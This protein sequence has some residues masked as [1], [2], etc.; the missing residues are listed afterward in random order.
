MAQ[1]PRFTPVAE[2]ALL[3]SFGDAIDDASGAAVLALDRAL[4]AAPPHG[5]TECVPAMVNLLVGFDPLR[6]DHDAVRAHVQQLLGRDAGTP[7]AGQLREVEVCYEGALAPDLAAVARAKG[8]SADAVIEQHL[9]GDYRVRMYGFA[10]G[11]AYLSGVPAA[12][13][14]PRKAAPLRDIAAGSVLIAGPQCLVTTLVM[15]TGWSI[16]GRSPTR[17][18]RPDA[19]APFLFDVGDRVRFTR[20]D[21]AQYAARAR[22]HD[23]G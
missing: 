5:M 17:I 23:D 10:P 7:A 16:I 20:I 3:V 13:Q 12:I 1:W 9:R 18:L 21:L 15:P 22:Q 8:L 11:Y 6:T 19:D 4:A 2:H 14:L